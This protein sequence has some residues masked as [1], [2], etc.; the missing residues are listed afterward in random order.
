ML[1]T[2]ELSSWA[3]LLLESRGAL[4][5]PDPD[6]VLRT[7][8]TPDLSQALKTN[9]WLQLRFGAGEGAD[10]PGEWLDRLGV[11]LPPHAQLI[12]ARRSSQEPAIRIDSQAVLARELV[13]PNGVYRLSEDWPE[14]AT[15]LFF[16]FAYRVESNERTEGL[17][18]MA[19]NSSAQSV[20]TLPDRL[21]EQARDRWLD[22]L[23]STPE[24]ALA[25]TLPVAFRRVQAEAR[26]AARPM[27]DNA[28]RRLDRD[29]ERVTHYY[30]GLL[31]QIE[32]RRRKATGEKEMRERS[33]AAATEADRAAKLDDLRNKYA[34]KVYLRL[35][36]VLV[37]PL[38]VWAISVRLIRKKEERKRVF[39]WNPILRSL[40]PPWCES[41]SGRAQPLFLCDDRVHCLCRE[42]LSPC[43]NCGKVYC[44]ACHKRC[45]CGVASK[46]SLL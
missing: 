4:V 18:T 12:V 22:D 41:C 23:A 39:H 24:V 34:V 43:L 27:C 45:K 16:N 32:K 33:R 37:A 6:G 9:D 14:T 17:L 40:E 1:A 11:L 10:D 46:S 38:P 5:E 25:A 31:E 30:A 19:L 3:R 8:L 7:L 20:V 15:Y 44:R 36:D 42:C 35:T 2:E 29:V 28:T 21:L 26:Q 13:L